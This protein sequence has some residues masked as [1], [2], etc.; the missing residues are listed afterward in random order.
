MYCFYLNKKFYPRYFTTV[1]FNNHHTFSNKLSKSL[2]WDDATQEKPHDVDHG[3]VAALRSPG[4]RL[5][6]TQFY[7]NLD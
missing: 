6:C 3:V 5:N 4:S 7:S 1:F 2:A